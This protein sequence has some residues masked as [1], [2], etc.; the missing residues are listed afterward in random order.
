MLAVAVL[1]SSCYGLPTTPHAPA[2]CDFPEGTHFAFIGNAS[3]ADL[4]FPG[5]D[6]QVADWWVTSERL[7]WVHLWKA[8]TPVPPPS[9]QACGV[10][11]DGSIGVQILPLDWHPPFDAVS[12]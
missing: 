4:R 11:P 2:G 12:S 9:P 8:S 7:P 1:L 5:G 6:S 10:F 3:R